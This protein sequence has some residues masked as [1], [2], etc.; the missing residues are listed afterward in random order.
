M[1]PTGLICSPARLGACSQGQE[2]GWG[3]R[4]ISASTGWPVSEPWPPRL[5]RPFP[6]TILDSPQS[7]LP[8]QD[9]WARLSLQ[10]SACCLGKSCL[11]GF[12]CTASFPP[13]FLKVL[14]LLPPKTQC[15]QVP[16]HPGL[17]SLLSQPCSL[18][19][20]SW[21]LP[22]SSLSSD[23]G[24]AGLRHWEENIRLG[25]YSQCRSCPRGTRVKSNQ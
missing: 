8:L 14:S 15:Q 4:K 18:A 11:Q 16:H 21:S 10:G 2:S 13:V 25:L 3:G 7:P 19:T 20:H 17:P 6:S 1:Q 23:S 12:L 9:P 5:T 22:L 24:T